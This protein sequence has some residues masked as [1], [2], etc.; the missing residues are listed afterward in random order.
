MNDYVI[1]NG[2][3]YHYGVP[4]MKWG[5]RRALNKMV[6]YEKKQLKYQDKA[7]RQL[8]L[9]DK[10]VNA[11]TAAASR[12]A[13]KYT[14]RMSQRATLSAAK[15]AAKRGEKAAKLQAKSDKW[16]RKLDKVADK[17]KIDVGQRTVAQYL[18]DANR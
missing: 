7:N 18:L 16:K 5:Q 15:T 12:M 17:H 6:K 1:T 3:L 8:T 2:E 13:G 14:N 11:K 4:G 9:K 10:V